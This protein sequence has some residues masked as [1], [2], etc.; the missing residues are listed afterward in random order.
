VADAVRIRLH[1]TAIQVSVGEAEGTAYIEAMRE[2][3][4][5]SGPYES[6]EVDPVECAHEEMTPTGSVRPESSGIIFIVYSTEPN[7]HN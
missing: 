3:Q 6:R 2:Q 5:G 4:C 7:T 1:Y